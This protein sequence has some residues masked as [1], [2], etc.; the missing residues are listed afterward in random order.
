MK[1]FIDSHTQNCRHNW[2]FFYILGQSNSK[3]LLLS[4]STDYIASQRYS[5][6]IAY[7]SGVASE[8]FVLFIK[9]RK[10]EFERLIRGEISSG[11]E[12]F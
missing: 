1:S 11:L 5:Y 12:L 10:F 4:Q 7:A 8:A 2:Y 9:V 6:E 3:L